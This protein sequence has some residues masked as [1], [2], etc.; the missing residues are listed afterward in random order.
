MSNLEGKVVIITGAA[1]GQGKAEAQLMAK[2]GAK[3]V[4]ADIDERGGAAADE[5]GENA[6]FVRH[7]V[8]SAEGWRDLVERTVRH[9]GGVDGLVNNAAILE[10]VALPDVTP[11]IF[12]RHYRINQLGPFLGMSAVL[13][14]MRQRGKGSIVNIASVAATRG[15][16]FHFSYSAAKWAVRG[17]THSAAMEL[18]PLGI[19]VNAVLPGAVMTQMLAGYSEKQLADAAA[20]LPLRRI[21][22][23]EDVAEVVAFLI[24]DASAY[25]AGAE[26]AVDGG[27]V[28]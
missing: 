6:L 5:I 24:S 22:D 15:M 2:K 11:D 13:E 21:G 1:G 16:P 23:P 17:M 8:S 18:G 7:D 27:F 25:M 19:R 14:P 12:E 3:V 28:A 26:V 20:M 4:L 9:F 10:M